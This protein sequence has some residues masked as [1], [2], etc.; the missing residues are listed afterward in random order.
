MVFKK[1]FTYTEKQKLHLDR[2]MQFL[3][4]R[5]FDEVMQ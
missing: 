1:N 2:N 5:I 3:E 4:R